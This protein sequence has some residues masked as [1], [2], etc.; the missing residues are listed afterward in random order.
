MGECVM[1][2]QQLKYAVEIA[3]KGS[4]S[5]AARSLFISQPSLSNAIRE[6]EA[7]IHISNFN[8]TNQGISLSTEGAEFLGYAT[9]MMQQYQLLEEKYINYKPSKQQF[10]VS[11][12]DYTFA[13]NA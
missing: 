13:V 2:L 4:F 6:L 7:E 3:N 8:R 1:K 9:Q 12:Q 5:E 10:S 11:A